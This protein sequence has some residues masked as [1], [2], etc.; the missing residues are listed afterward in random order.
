MTR[1]RKPKPAELRIVEGNPGRRPL[2]VKDPSE[3]PLGTA[4]SELHEIERAAWRRVRRE[5]PWLKRADR[6]LVE[7]FCRSWMQMVTADRRLVDAV[8]SGGDESEMRPL[9]R[10]LE[11]ARTACL[12]MMAEM[13]ATASS[14]ARV[15]GFGDGDRREDPAERYFGRGA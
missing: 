1:G 12:R 15:K 2:P 7:M 8:N 10:M 9:Q 3:Q 11:Q 6:M 14:R 5:C 13:G 4:P